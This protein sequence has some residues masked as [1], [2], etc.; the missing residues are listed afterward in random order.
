[1]IVTS[2]SAICS[3]PFVPVAANALKNQAVLVSGLATGIIG[4]AAGNYLGI[5]VNALFNLF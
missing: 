1:M 3:P 2:I 4:Y 5:A